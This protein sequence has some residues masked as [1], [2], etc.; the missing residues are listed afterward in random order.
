MSDLDAKS[1]S[2]EELNDIINEENNVNSSTKH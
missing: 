1:D 2:D